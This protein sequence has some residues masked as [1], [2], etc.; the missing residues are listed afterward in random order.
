[1]VVVV[2][3]MGLTIAKKMGIAGADVVVGGAQKIWKAPF[4]L[5]GKGV[6]VGTKMAAGGL[7]GFTKRW[8]T[9]AVARKIGGAAGEAQTAKAQGYKARLQAKLKRTAAERETNP[10]KKA[11]LLAE[12]GRFDA[13]A[14]AADA[15][16][17]RASI[18]SAGWRALS[19][20]DT[21]TITEAWKKRQ[22]E[23]DLRTYGMAVCSIK[24]T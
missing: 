3:A 2:L 1:M 14:E 5:A 6:S 15:K 19:L 4:A 20:L 9:G 23:K 7:F 24:D 13:L 16:K 10:D 17:R 12:A 8:F 11:A 18:R 21:R 22:H